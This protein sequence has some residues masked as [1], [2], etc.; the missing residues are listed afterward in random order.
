MRD[1]IREKRL[2]TVEEVAHCTR[3]AT[4]C[5]SCYDDIQAILD[6]AAGRKPK[7]S[8]APSAY[9]V[10]YRK[11]LD[12]IGALDAGAVKFELVDVDGDRVLAYVRAPGGDT[13]TPEL[14]ALKR[15][16]VEAMSAACG[17]R[18]Q[19]IELNQVEAWKQR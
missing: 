15:R 16:F 3:A 14:L 9:A 11:V 13:S 18:M 6:E 10:T 8:P 5:S 17:R 4:G 7:A 1:A 12:V 19:L 2:T